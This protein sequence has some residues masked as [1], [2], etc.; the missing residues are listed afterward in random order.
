[1]FFTLILPDLTKVDILAV[2]APSDDCPEFWEEAHTRKV[3]S[4]ILETEE[5]IDSYR[6][7]NPDSQSYTYRNKKGN[8][9]G[10][11]D[12]GLISPFLLPLHHT[13]M[14]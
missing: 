14:T 11:L 9:R 1:M 5:L 2:Y 6:H 13:I 10:R 4:G 7:F 12:H 3:L 8:L